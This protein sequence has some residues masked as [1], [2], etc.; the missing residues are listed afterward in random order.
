MMKTSLSTILP[1]SKLLRLT[2]AVFDKDL[3]S[4][5]SPFRFAF[6]RFGNVVRERRNPA[7]SH[8]ISTVVFRF[9]LG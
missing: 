1:L 9:E 7:P 5:A 6:E 8:H 2:I 3:P 4:S